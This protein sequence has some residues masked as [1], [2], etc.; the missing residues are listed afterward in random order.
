VDSETSTVWAVNYQ[1][2]ASP[3]TLNSGVKMPFF[4]LRLNQGSGKMFTMIGAASSGMG[5]NL[6][7]L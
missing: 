5:Q 6:F 3:P 7:V 4:A 2:L 1:V